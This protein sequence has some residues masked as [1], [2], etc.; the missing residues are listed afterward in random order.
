MKDDADKVFKITDT[1]VMGVAG[2]TCD[3]ERFSSYIL[4]NIALTKYRT[5]SQLD[6]DAIAEFTRSELAYAIRRGPF[7]TNILIGGVDEDGKA[8]LFWL[9][10]MGTMQQTAKGAHGYAGYFTT[11]ILE[12]NYKV[13]LTQAEGLEIMKKCANEMRTRFLLDQTKFIV[14]VVTKDGI[15]EHDI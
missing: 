13:G 14:K 9:D 8:K 10:Y 15:E 11:S 3:R 2:E 12:D 1:S 6:L 5:G 4:R 7:Q